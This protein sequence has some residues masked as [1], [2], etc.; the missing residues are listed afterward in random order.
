MHKLSYLSIKG[1]FNFGGTVSPKKSA[2]SAIFNKTLL[3]MSPKY[4]P[5]IIFSKICKQ[6]WKGIINAHCSFKPVIDK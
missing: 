2:S 1:I 5:E 3:T 4:I 6:D